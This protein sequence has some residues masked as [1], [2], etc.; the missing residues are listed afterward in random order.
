MLPY[1]FSAMTM[2]AVGKAAI[3]MVKEVRRQFR[4]QRILSGEIEP[5][6]KRCIEVSTVS[7]L[8]SM[9]LPGLLI[10]LTPISLGVLFHP[11]FLVGL[12]PGALVSGIQLAL[13][14]SNSGGA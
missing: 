7:S 1:I 11:V 3:K 12:L 9:V 2:R 14:M 5:D 6:Y 4:D 8:N 10:I 13:S